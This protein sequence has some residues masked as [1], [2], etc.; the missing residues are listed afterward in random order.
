MKVVETYCNKFS[1]EL[2]IIDI[3]NLDNLDTIL[4]ARIQSIP[5]TVFY[6]IDGTVKF[7][8]MGVMNTEEFDML[9]YNNRH[10]L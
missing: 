9:I 2:Q 4:A 7:T 1:T 5:F 6:D 8:S 10:S 3:D